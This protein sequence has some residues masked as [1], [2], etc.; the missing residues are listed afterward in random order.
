MV[1]WPESSTRQYKV[2]CVFTMVAISMLP[3]AELELNYYRDKVWM[4][5][6]Y[7]FVIYLNV[8]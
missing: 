3:V 7:N 6:Q 5:R 8:T 2:V 4:N 1:I